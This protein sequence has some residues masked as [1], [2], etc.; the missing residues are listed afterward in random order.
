MS[1]RLLQILVFV[2][3]LSV[4]AVEMTGLRLLAPFF[5]TSLIVTTILIGSMMGFLSLGYWL[6]GRWGDRHPE[7]SSLCKVTTA[8]SVFILLIPFIGQPIL[9]AAASTLRPLLQGETLS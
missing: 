2:S 9:Q 8:A 3:G 4:M 7:F 1:Q 6:G 5:G